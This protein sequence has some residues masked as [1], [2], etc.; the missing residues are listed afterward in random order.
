M[1]QALILKLGTGNF[2]GLD[3]HLMSSSVP[4]GIAKTEVILES[5]R[6]V[7]VQE[8]SLTQRLK[9]NQ[10]LNWI[11]AS[12]LT[13]SPNGWRRLTNGSK[14]QMSPVANVSEADKME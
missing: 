4:S 10:D 8:C 1:F 7:I 5:W 14:V 6:L 2:L 11:R 3:E 12:T 9:V 13:S